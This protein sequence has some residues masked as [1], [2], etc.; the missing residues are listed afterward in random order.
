M[1]LSQAIEHALDGNAILFLGAGFS[2][3]AQNLRDKP[4]MTGG[5][6]ASYLAR[7]AGIEEDALLEDAAEEYM[8]RFGKDRL[9]KELFNEFS[10]RDVTKSHEIIAQVPWKALYTTNYDNVSEVA[11]TRVG[12][13][14]VSLTLDDNMKKT[15]RGDFTHCV[16][17]NGY[18]QKLNRETLENEFK[19]T[20]LS[21][22]TASL[23]DSPWMTKF[24]DDIRSSR[25]VFF[26]GYSLQSDLDI[27]RILHA[28][29]SLKDKCVFI[30][31]N[32]PSAGT[33][34][35]AQQYG[36]PF[37]LST[38]ELARNIEEK[39]ASYS[40]RV[41]EF[42]G[43]SIVK[44]QMPSNRPNLFTDK[45]VFDLLLYGNVNPHF[46]HFDPPNNQKYYLER[47]QVTALI[48]ALDKE[49][50]VVVN[51]DLGNGKT[52]F[53]EGVKFR[54]LEKGY[55]VFEVRNQSDAMISE[56]DEAIKRSRR[57]LLIVDN[58]HNWMDVV[59][60]YANHAGDNSKILM[61]A[62]SSINDVLI[63]DLTN[64]FD[65]NNIAEVSLDKLTEREI[66]WVNDLLDSYGLWGGKAALSADRKLQ[67]IRYLGGF[68]AL[69]LDLLK[70]PHILEKLNVLVEG[71]EKTHEYYDVVLSV[72][73][74]AVLNYSPTMDKLTDFWG[75]KVLNSNFRNN[76]LA[77]QILEINTDEVK[78][79]SSVLARYILRDVVNP[80]E[81][82][83]VLIR[84]AQ[85]AE[86]R[87]A[88]SPHYAHM[89]KNLMKFSNVQSVL[90]DNPKLS[91]FVRYYENIKNHK[92]SR[93]NPLFWLQY[94]IACLAFK[95][96]TRAESYFKTAYAYGQA[97]AFD[98]FQIDNHYARYLI[99]RSISEK[100]WR[101]PLEVFY[102]ADG[103]VKRQMANERLSYPYR[104]AR[105]Y[106]GFYKEHR[107]NLA[108]EDRREVV[109][110][111]TSIYVKIRDFPREKQAL[112]SYRECANAMKTIINLG[113]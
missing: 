14:L 60:H 86:E 25:A 48:N 70:S 77:R 44:V 99:M 89:F 105:L 93:E 83:D 72:L 67:R 33:L 32:E 82:I 73:I 57:L 35:R 42:A 65:V 9:I 54:A 45:L 41:V 110:I 43:K 90:P 66:K 22:I 20:D 17:I 95:D 37:T 76:E 63:D 46:V 62:R 11:Y 1:E 81:T 112:K 4:I 101:D 49:K 31:G 39:K 56:L 104:V 113:A 23:A 29:E 24:R 102:E 68:Q 98:L 47:D 108:P 87:A 53:L 8:A 5:Q 61:T 6:L 12:K 55:D 78:L 106:A 71:F 30:I 27:R 94:A 69:L 36:T 85:V 15:P 58:Y 19:L 34:R 51:S 18:I 16:H 74:L 10:A 26:V 13:K 91:L 7:I 2:V 28:T 96:F 100:D 88:I 111:A 109:K 92:R 52:M 64:F 40:P 107:K 3:G 79:R 103:I 80:D 38:D 50:V 59:E 21:Y 84:M 75:V 97:R